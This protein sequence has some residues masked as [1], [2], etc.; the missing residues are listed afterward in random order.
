MH[1]KARMLLKPRDDNRA[2][3]GGVVVA[4]QV[5]GFLWRRLAINLL[6][7]GEP[8]A[9]T[10]AL[11]AARDDAAVECTHGGKQGGGAVAFV[12]MCHRGRAPWPHQ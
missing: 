7:K 3:V 5:Q 8:F 1:V 12:V 4:D 10:T 11:F 9:V 6:Q 2:L